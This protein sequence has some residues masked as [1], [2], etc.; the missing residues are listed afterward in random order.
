MNSTDQM[1]RMAGSAPRSPPRTR[2]M[3]ARAVADAA[4]GRLVG[5]EAGRGCSPALLGAGGGGG[6]PRHGS[7]LH[8][9]GF[10]GAMPSRR[11]GPP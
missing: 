10:G 3:Y 8:C 7:D 1:P 6:R 11:T 2:S 9:G 5:L 4:I